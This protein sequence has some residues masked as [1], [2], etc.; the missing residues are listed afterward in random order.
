MVPLVM[1]APVLPDIHSSYGKDHL[2]N[3]CERIIS[4]EIAGEKAH[5]WLGWVQACVC[6]SGGA[7]LDRLKLI[8]R[9]A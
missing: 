4:G 7:N 8:N 6:I 9:E 1:H 2:V 3:M 5:R